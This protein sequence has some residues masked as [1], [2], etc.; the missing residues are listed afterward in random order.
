LY[1]CD[2]KRIGRDLRKR[3]DER[4]RSRVL[5]SVDF[6]PMDWRAPR[7]RPLGHPSAVKSRQNSFVVLDRAGPCI[8]AQSPDGSNFEYLSAE[9]NRLETQSPYR[10]G[11]VVF[12][13]STCCSPE[14]NTWT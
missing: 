3:L 5:T 14:W 12:R 6:F 11:G 10:Q 4:R 1:A 2:V 7:H 8:S 13:G 9:P